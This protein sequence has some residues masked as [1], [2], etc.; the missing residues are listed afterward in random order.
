MT[1]GA[2]N[3]ISLFSTSDTVVNGNTTSNNKVDGIYVGGP[4]S[5]V[6]D[7]PPPET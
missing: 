4:G 1:G 5:T 2:D 3:G 6:S 7:M